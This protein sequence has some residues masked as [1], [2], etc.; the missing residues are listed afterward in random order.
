MENKNLVKKYLVI[1]V[2]LLS[3]IMLQD[4]HAQFS[5]ENSNTS[6]YAA[7]NLINVTLGGDFPISGTYSASRTERVDQLITRIFTT[8]KAELLK[9][10]PD[11]KLLGIIKTSVDEYA[12]RDLVLKRFTGEEIIIDLVKFR[13]TGNFTFNPYLKNDDVIIFPPLDLERN[14]ID[15]TG[16]VNKEIK[17]QFVENDKLSDALIIA[18]GINPAYTN[19][20]SA[21]ISRLSY[22]GLNE[23]ILNVKIS[24][25]PI[26][27]RGDRIRILSDE[28]N[29]KDYNVLVLGEVNRP[30]KIHITK[31]NTTLTDVIKK[32][33][34]FTKNA[35]LKFAELIRNSDSYSVLKKNAIE[36]NFST[37]NITMGAEQ[38]LINKKMIEYLKMFR[39]ANL[40]MSDTLYFGIDNQ[41]RTLN[42]FSQL[43]FRNL[44][45]N[46]SFESTYFVK[47]G[48]IVIVPEKINEVYVWGGVS[49]IGYY[50]YKNNSTVWD[51]IENAGGFTEIAYGEDEVYLIKGKSRD[52]ITVTEDE[53]VRVEAGDFIYVKKERPVAEFWFYLSRIS[54]VA[55]ILG[56]IATVVLLLTQFGK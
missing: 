45:N 24:D 37:L 38:K 55:G 41:L 54:A 16:A 39:A 49:K 47:N 46:T 51:Y 29:K 23:E 42:G 30:G 3:L 28:N 53:S 25:N 48:D 10:T 56:S 22:D 43:D 12:K 26:L 20:D 7:L 11:E 19:V 34:G 6:G 18:Q 21:Q 1:I 4:I 8:Y 13:V 35:S 17:F 40:E 33:G 15:I 52:W 36:K 32:A 44:N 14:F 5:G 27:Q 50:P 31:N 9:T 2:I